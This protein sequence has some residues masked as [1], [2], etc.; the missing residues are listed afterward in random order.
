MAAH[1]TLNT[2]FHK[3]PIDRRIFGGFLEHLGRAVYGG[4]YDPA[5]PKSD[6]QGLR[7]DVLEALAGL[8][9]PVIRYPGGNYVSAYDWKHTVGPRSARPRRPDYAWQSIETNQFGIGEFMGFCDALGTAPMLAVN[10]GTAGAAEAADLVEYCNLQ[11][12]TSWADLRAEHGRAA[13]YGVKLWGLGNELDG[14]WQAG[15]VPAA[16]YARRAFQASFLMKQLD[17]GIETVAAGSSGRGMSTYLAWDR[18]V[19][20]TCFDTIDFISA[21]RYSENRN[22]D[23]AWY[24]AEG[25][26]IDRILADYAGLIDYVRGLKRSNKRIYLAFDEWN[27]WYRAR[28]GEHSRGGWREAPPLLEETYNLE[29]ALVC[30]QYL[31]AFLRRADLVKVACIAQIVNVIAPIMTRSDALFLQTIYHPFRMFS[32]AARGVALTPLIVA[33]EYAAGARGAVP[34]LDAAASFDPETGQTAVFLINRSCESA[35][36]V[37]VR[38]EDRRFSGTAVHTLLGGANVKAENGWEA[39]N[40][41]RPEPGL[42]QRLDNGALRLRVPAPG[43]SVLRSPTES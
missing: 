40:R 30:A 10:L 4:V 24:L 16:E 7:R 8:H 15:H 21:H 31:A 25:V 23:A 2:G 1:I 39:P 35:L 19:L 34:V 36:E 41:V 28:G 32:E 13:P 43:L 18:E 9:M 42:V 14:P 11:R 5:C 38:I 12:G 17:P 22:N 20:E 3:G 27:V 26:E 29:D 33:P 6:E 37:D